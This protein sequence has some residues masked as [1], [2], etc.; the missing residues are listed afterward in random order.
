MSSELKRWVAGVLR[1]AEL[2]VTRFRTAHDDLSPVEAELRRAI[3]GANRAEDFDK[4]D[5]VNHVRAIMMREPELKA[6]L[7]EQFP[8]GTRPPPFR[9][10][11]ER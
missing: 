7:R 6:L 4:V 5:K 3:D 2:A 1:V 8:E 9:N 11:S 10:T